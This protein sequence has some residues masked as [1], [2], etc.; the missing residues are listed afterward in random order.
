MTRNTDTARATRVSCRHVPRKVAQIGGDCRREIVRAAPPE[1]SSSM[2]LRAC[3]TTLF[4]NPARAIVWITQL[5][6]PSVPVSFM[7]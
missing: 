4:T 2:G 5:C 3:K 7:E 6:S 1:G